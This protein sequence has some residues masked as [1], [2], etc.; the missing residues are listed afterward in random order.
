MNEQLCDFPTVRLI[1]RKREDHLDGA[2]QL[3]VGE[4]REQET[5][6][7]PHLRRETCDCKPRVVVAERCQVADRRAAVDAVEE[8]TCQRVELLVELGRGQASDNDLT[9]RR[10][11]RQPEVRRS[12]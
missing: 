5:V 12:W 10:H 8:H 11:R 9:A 1:R 2:D 3:A 4:R 7:A 6:A